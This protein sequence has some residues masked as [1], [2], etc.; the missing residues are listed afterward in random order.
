MGGRCEVATVRSG[1][2]LGDR[3]KRDCSEEMRSAQ[4]PAGLDPLFSSST[5]KKN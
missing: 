2:S 3:A 4:L 1:G 5:Q